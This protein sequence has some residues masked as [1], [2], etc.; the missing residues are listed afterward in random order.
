MRKPKVTKEDMLFRI[1]SWCGGCPFNGYA[2]PA[3]CRATVAAIRRLIRE[4]KGKP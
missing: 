3:K 1:E 4:S 2:C